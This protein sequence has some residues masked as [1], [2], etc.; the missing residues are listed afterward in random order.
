MQKTIKII[1][2]T[3]TFPTV[4]STSITFP[5]TDAIEARNCIAADDDDDEDDDVDDDKEEEAEEDV[6]KE[7][8]PREYKTNND[9]GLQVNEYT[10]PI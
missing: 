2:C 4:V 8:S 1:S 9:S 10:F 6:F 5:A 3:F 7:A